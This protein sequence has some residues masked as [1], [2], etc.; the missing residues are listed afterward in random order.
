MATSNEIAAADALGFITPVGSDFISD[1]DD[2]ITE[3]AAVTAR[4]LNRRP[5]FENLTDRKPFE[6]AT[7]DYNSIDLGEYS[8]WS[9][10]VARQS[11][12]PDPGNGTLS[13][14][15]DEYLRT[16][17]WTS[18]DTGTVW[19]NTRG[20]GSN[21]PTPWRGWE[22]IGPTSAALDR[23][24]SLLLS[25]PARSVKIA[26]VG[27]SISEGTGTSALINR[28]QTVAQTMLREALGI[29]RGPL[30]P[31]IPA[32][33]ATSAPQSLVSRSGDTDAWDR[34]GLGV[35]SV[36]INAGGSVT[37]TPGHVTSAR[38]L[39][40]GGSTAGE[41]EVLVN[42]TS[43][44]TVATAGKGNAYVWQVPVSPGEATITVRPSGTASVYLQG[45]HVYD[46]DE[47]AGLQLIDAS[48]HGW[49]WQAENL[50]SSQSQ[51]AA[52]KA[53]NI[54]G[55]LGALG[56]NDVLRG[57]P[58][59]AAAAVADVLNLWR[60]QVP[61]LPVVELWMPRAGGR[62]TSQTDPYR[63]AVSRAFNTDERSGFV[64][65]GTVLPSPNDPGGAGLYA[66]ALHPNDDGAARIA[67]A[68]SGVLLAG[69]VT[70]AGFDS[71][72]RQHSHPI[73][74]VAGLRAEL[75]TATARLAALD[76]DTGWRAIAPD[77]GTSGRVLL[78]RVGREVTLRLEDF[79]P[80]A[81]NYAVHV[82]TL[83]SGFRYTA[84]H[85]FVAWGEGI[86]LYG[87]YSG[88]RVSWV[89]NLEGAVVHAR[90]TS[91]QSATYTFHTDDPWPTTLPGTPA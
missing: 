59:D 22:R 12:F 21:G 51:A 82:A 9:T 30:V 31:Y 14:W 64:D 32:H 78:R 68:V 2:A 73:A 80:P 47:T 4:E 60:G 1:G 10:L 17:E 6:T 52:F 8:V 49:A 44:G 19:R 40:Y 77:A 46:G 28:W 69:S 53:L 34:V 29:T 5:M 56:T 25:A 50:L 3:N 90:P 62:P 63:E 35:R 83:S 91:P 67:A 15:G 74:E 72:I 84:P 75:D 43:R 54:E 26:V 57:S 85:Y 37:F 86:S 41:A 61:T 81:G 16:M 20:G 65:L 79:L 89:R 45:L 11:G 27:D 36:R 66:D 88:A 23:L 42:G 33:Y 18:T 48:H 70:G 24:R 87:L 7:T 71:P 39:F 38:L 58:A 13:V 76:R 55:A